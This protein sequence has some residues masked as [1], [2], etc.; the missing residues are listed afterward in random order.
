MILT[1]GETIGLPAKSNMKSGTERLNCPF[2]MRMVLGVFSTH[3]F[4]HV[5][6]FIR[7]LAQGLVLKVSYSWASF[8]QILVLKVP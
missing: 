3:C 8:Y 4:V 5:F 6:Y 2:K 7:N 1:Q